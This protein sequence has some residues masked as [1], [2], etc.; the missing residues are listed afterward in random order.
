MGT[1]A[2]GNIPVTCMGTISI[3]VMGI[4]SI[5]SMGNISIRSMG[6]IPISDIKPF[7]YGFGGIKTLDFGI[8]EENSV[9]VMERNS[10]SGI[11]PLLLLY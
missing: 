2:L 10:L 7:K 1:I 5:T 8:W 11:K 4:I 3:T 6:T 9:S